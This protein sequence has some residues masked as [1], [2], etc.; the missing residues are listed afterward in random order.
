MDREILVSIIVPVYNVEEYLERCIESVLN[1]T[2]NNIELILVDDGSTDKSSF[3][4]D[5][6][7]ENDKRVKVFHQSNKGRCIARNVGLN[8]SVGEWILF[9]DSDDWI[10]PDYIRSMIDVYNETG[11]KII[12]CKTQVWVGDEI[13]DLNKDTNNITVYNLDEIIKGLLTQETIRFELWNKLIKKELLDGVVFIDGQISEEVHIDRIIFLR[14]NS[15]AHIDK[16]LHN[17]LTQRP[18]NTS[19]RFNPS[20]IC[21]FDELDGMAIDLESMGKKNLV[22]VI[23][24]IAM[25]FVILI[26]MEALQFKRINEVKTQLNIYIDKY[27][28]IAKNSEYYQ[29]R[30]GLKIFKL[31]PKIYYNLLRVKVGIKQLKI[32]RKKYA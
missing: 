11:S 24:C 31:S 27:Y 26:Y 16:S 23:D 21:I 7:A 29:N 10:E 20:R 5:K 12:S 3:I 13:L 22:E 8:N 9:L 14:T 15:L 19:S 28:S 1:Q 2:E 4:C 18:G 32:R 17:Y 25:Q 6:Y 30:K